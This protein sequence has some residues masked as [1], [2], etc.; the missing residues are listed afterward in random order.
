MAH[1]GQARD[2]TL[3]VPLVLPEAFLRRSP[4]GPAGR[5]ACLEHEKR[6][7]LLSR[8]A[9]GV[10]PIAFG[11]SGSL[12]F[13]DACDHVVL[14]LPARVNCGIGCRPVSRRLGIDTL[15]LFELCP[16]TLRT[17]FVPGRGCRPTLF[18][19]G[20]AGRLCGFLC[21]TMASKEGSF[22]FGGGT[23]AIAKIIVST[24]FQIRIPLEV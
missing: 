4:C 16:F 17:S 20:K 6:T 19:P 13:D 10:A 5:A 24:V 11:F 12:V 1:P 3:V 18:L 23:A 22:C 14:A 21:G 8:F 15:L 7:L 9:L 2:R